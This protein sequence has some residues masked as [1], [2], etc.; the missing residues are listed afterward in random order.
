M[1]IKLVCIVSVLALLT[2]CAPRGGTS[3]VS[4]PDVSQEP[5]PHQHLLAVQALH[6]KKIWQNSLPLT[7]FLLITPG[8]ISIYIHQRNENRG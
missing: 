6:P 7:A 2:S 1:K 5:L 3:S 8:K 4:S